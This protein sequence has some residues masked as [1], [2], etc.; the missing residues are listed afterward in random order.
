MLEDEIKSFLDR[1]LSQGVFIHAYLKASAMLQKNGEVIEV[2][3]FYPDD[4]CLGVSCLAIEWEKE[5]SATIK[6][7][8]NNTKHP[9]FYTYRHIHH[10]CTFVS[11]MI[12]TIF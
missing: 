5:L 1:N 11:L 2:E 8:H 9:T 4:L 3:G 12:S 10:I 6:G 7:H